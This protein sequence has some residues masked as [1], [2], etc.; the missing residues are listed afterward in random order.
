MEP[1][2]IKKSTMTD[3]GQVG[4]KTDSD[5]LAKGMTQCVFKWRKNGYGSAKRSPVAN[6]AFFEESNERATVLNEMGIKLIFWHAPRERNRSAGKLA[7]DILD[8]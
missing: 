6:R 4:I 7:N 5:Y 2:N 3:L 1:A 8:I